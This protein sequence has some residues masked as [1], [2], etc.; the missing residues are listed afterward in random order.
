M[1]V[2]P[3]GMP[4]FLRPWLGTCCG[5]IRMP[6]TP[7][8][9]HGVRSCMGACYAG[10]SAQEALIYA[11]PSC[12]RLGAGGGHIYM[13]AYY[14]DGSAREALIYTCPSCIRLGAGG[15]HIYGCV[16]RRW[17]GA[18][19]AHIYMPILPTTRRERRPYIYG[20]VLRRWLGAGGAH[21]Y[22][23]VTPMAGLDHCIGENPAPSIPGD[24]RQSKLTSLPRENQRHEALRSAAGDRRVEKVPEIEAIF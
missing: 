24:L 19:G 21:I 14:A 22:M 7:M 15:G 2:R 4:C 18:G 10:G 23:P 13:G 6:I 5:H 1:V 20:C 9:G 3:L 16:L 11:C 12:I 17:L 8:A